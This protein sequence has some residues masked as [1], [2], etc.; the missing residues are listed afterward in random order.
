M[1][2]PS[3]DLLQNFLSIMYRQS[4]FFILLAIIISGM[5]SVSCQ[6]ADKPHQV[7]DVIDYVPVQV[8]EE[9][10]WVFVDHTGTR[11][12][13]QKW[14]FKP[15]V[16][17]GGVFIAQVDSGLT[18][19]K[20][21]RDVAKPIT[22]LTDL[23]EAGS[24]NEEVIPVCNRR[25][26]LRIANAMGETVF[27]LNPIDGKEIKSCAVAMSDGMLIITDSD[28]K[29]GAVDK[30]GNI[31]VKPAYDFIGDF[32]EGVA[33]AVNF[34]EN[35]N[36]YSDLFI[37]D[38]KGNVTKVNKKIDISV[39][40]FDQYGHDFI[41]G[42]CYVRNY[43]KTIIPFNF[44]KISTDG[45]VSGTNTYIS[46]YSYL[47]DGSYIEELIDDSTKYILKSPNGKI[48]K[49]F[50]EGYCSCEGKFVC[51]TIICP[52]STFHLNPRVN[53]DNYIYNIE[54]KE[55][56][57]YTGDYSSCYLGGKFGLLLINF[58][59]LI[60]PISVTMIDEN[61]KE[62]PKFHFANCGISRDIVLLHPEE[63]EP[64]SRLAVYSNYND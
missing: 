55:I 7:E 9:S 10:P 12:G 3:S 38:K 56:A 35:D 27:T 37:I 57:N 60:K 21:D 13:T 52:T 20:W 34:P 23:V 24:Y 48:I 47:T 58:N 17:K 11:I 62:I 43:D 1:S 50:T 54:G 49:E 16:S 18:V 42:Y 63:M 33:L 59:E 61:G 2:A 4:F 44:I 22:G 39:D 53:D 45:N 26:R 31:I 15:T 40:D 8:S 25:E 46:K 32:S 36:G 30:E 28:G 51:N 5:T 64:W 29:S 19:Y 14:E 41:H 6:S